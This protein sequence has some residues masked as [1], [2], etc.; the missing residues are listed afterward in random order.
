M[1][2]KAYLS[3]DERQIIERIVKIQLNSLEHIANGD[4]GTDLTMYCIANELNENDFQDQVSIMQKHWET[5]LHNPQ[6]V[7]SLDNDNLR[8]FKTILVNIEAEKYQDG[9]WQLWGKLNCLD[10]LNEYF[11]LN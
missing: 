4:I 5:L 10:K 7:F 1:I 2:K 9:K 3:F 8:T 11:S 6:G